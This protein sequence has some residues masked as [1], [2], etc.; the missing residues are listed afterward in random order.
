MSIML[1]R[2]S[3]QASGPAKLHCLLTLCSYENFE[4]SLCEFKPRTN[5]QGRRKHFKLGGAR[6]FKG[7]F[8]ARKALL[9]TLNLQKW[10]KIPI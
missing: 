7:T 5:K 10:G 6:H 3:K 4:V 8:A 1:R 9:N 2:V